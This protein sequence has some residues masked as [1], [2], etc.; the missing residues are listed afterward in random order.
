MARQPFRKPNNRDLTLH[1]GNQFLTERP[2][3]ATIIGR[4]ILRW[5]Q[6][7]YLMAVLLAVLL[8]TDTPA[9]MS[10]FLTLRRSTSRIEAITAAAQHLPARDKEICVATL[11]AMQSVEAE[12]N[13]LA[14]GMFGVT[15]ELP[16]SVLWAE[17][18]DI[19]STMVKYAFFADSAD[20]EKMSEYLDNVFYYRESDLL[21]I[22]EQIK[23]ASVVLT[24]AIRYIRSTYGWADSH[25][26]LDQQYALLCSFAPIQEALRA[27]RARAQ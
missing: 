19:S 17:V 12:R 22:E 24:A 23:Q 8:K 16:D 26:E 21:Q 7:E 25:L 1:W 9:A 20:N 18:K 10:V 5:T 13:S 2:L 11:K 15:D 6:I 3:L 27:L 14:H 4:S